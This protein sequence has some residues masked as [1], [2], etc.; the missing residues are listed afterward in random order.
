MVP[1]LSTSPPNPA[2]KSSTHGTN[3]SASDPGNP[4]MVRNTSVGYRKA[5]SVTKSQ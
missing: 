1:C 3:R 2:K 4:S 5:N